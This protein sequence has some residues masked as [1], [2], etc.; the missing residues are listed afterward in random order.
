MEKEIQD[1]IDSKSYGEILDKLHELEGRYPDK[2]NT[3]TKRLYGVCKAVLNGA[4][5]NGL[6]IEDFK[7]TSDYEGIIESATAPAGPGAWIPPDNRAL[8][9]ES[10]DV[11]FKA[12]V[13]R[14]LVI[15]FPEDEKYFSN[16]NL[17]R[18]DLQGREG[19]SPNGA[20]R[21]HK[22]RVL[23][24]RG[25]RSGMLW[26]ELY[27]LTAGHGLV[28]G[29]TMQMV[30]N[31]SGPNFDA[32][33]SVSAYNVRSGKVI[34]VTHCGAHE[35][36]CAIIKLDS[37]FNTD[38]GVSVSGLQLNNI[39]QNPISNP[40]IPLK[41]AG[42][43]LGMMAI[44]DENAN[45]MQ[46]PTGYWNG[47]PYFFANLDANAGSSGAP[48][49]I[50]DNNS[51][52]ICGMVVASGA[53]QDF[54]PKEEK[55]DWLIRLEKFAVGTRILSISNLLATIT[56]LLNNKPPAFPGVVATNCTSSSGA[57][58][59]VICLEAYDVKITHAMLRFIEKPGISNPIS[60]VNLSDTH[61]FRLENN[62]LTI[63][64]ESLD[65]ALKDPTGVPD[66]LRVHEENWPVSL[67]THTGDGLFFWANKKSTDF[68]GFSFPVD[69]PLFL[70]DG[71]GTADSTLR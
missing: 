41:Y 59:M 3:K 30:L 70:L 23:E 64:K 7:S 67:F 57:Y 35:L 29:E 71:I 33:D 14:S 2:P 44:S 11:D 24:V 58:P 36:D 69:T 22:Q 51:Y 28:C 1:I 42:H 68:P 5:S 21:F 47:S 63:T 12:I 50:L 27:V 52:K 9:H 48:V 34:A 53:L 4:F 46:N 25:S 20:I 16:S 8:L 18:K 40:G 61:C 26:D 39:Y 10:S 65:Q 19:R 60:P 49:F 15:V 62:K 31:Y 55:L 54:D 45:S 66:R 17:V 56:N 37:P 13:A 32:K 6:T 43:P 38:K